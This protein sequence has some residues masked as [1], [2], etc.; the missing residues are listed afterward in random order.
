M[1]GRAEPALSPAAHGQIRLSL[2]GK[3]HPEG[4]QILFLVI[5]QPESPLFV[6]ILHGCNPAGTNTVTSATSLT[7]LGEKQTLTDLKAHCPSKVQVSFS[8]ESYRG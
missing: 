2:N 3:L 7:G 5:A 1:A 8:P 4:Q 6:S